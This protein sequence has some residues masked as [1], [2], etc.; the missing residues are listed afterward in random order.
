[1]EYTKGPWEW[2][3]DELIGVEGTPV[4]DIFKHLDTSSCRIIAWLRV[5]PDGNQTLIQFAPDLYEAL[6]ALVRAY[7]NMS[8]P[9]LCKQHE[10]WRAAEN[11]LLKA[12]GK[13]A[14]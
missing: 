7:N 14:E 12:E 2:K 5:N 8:V 9:E 6:N 13:E 1:M 4:I 11:A 3:D 10:L